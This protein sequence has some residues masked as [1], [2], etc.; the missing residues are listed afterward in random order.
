M[1]AKQPL[2]ELAPVLPSVTGGSA[3]G[4]SIF[5][6]GGSFFGGGGVGGGDA[7]GAG[8]VCGATW[9]STLVRCTVLPVINEGEQG[10]LF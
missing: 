4:G 3:F 9:R 6:G 2:F 8:V 5:G 7:G 1:P 10:S